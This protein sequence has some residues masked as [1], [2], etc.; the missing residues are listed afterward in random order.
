MALINRTWGNVTTWPG[1]RVRV[2][3]T[4]CIPPGTLVRTVDHPPRLTKAET[5]DWWIDTA[6]SYNRAHRIYQ[7]H[8]PYTHVVTLEEG[9]R[10]NS[11]AFFCYCTPLSGYTSAAGDGVGVGYRPTNWDMDPAPLRTLAQ[12]RALLNAGRFHSLLGSDFFQ[13]KQV[14]SMFENV[15]RRSVNAVRSLRHGKIEEALRS[16]GYH[17]PRRRLRGKD[18]ASQWL[19]IQYGWKPLWADLYDSFS[20]L[21]SM[22]NHALMKGVGRAKDLRDKVYRETVSS[23]FIDHHRKETC[24]TRCQLDFTLVDSTLLLSQ[25]LGLLNPL[26]TIWDL[27]P[28]SFVIDWFF[29]IGDYFQSLSALAGLKYLGGSV[30]SKQK[31][32]HTERGVYTPPSYCGWQSG[33][34]T[35]LWDIFMFKR[36]VLPDPPSYILKVKNPFSFMH[37]A[38][39]LALAFQRAF[40]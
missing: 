4:D 19:E 33:S 30:S 23:Y 40:R 34:S 14:F 1:E 28:W 6:F 37:G 25:Q 12:N 20:A 16:L 29:P 9:P 27:T 3:A 7:Q 31:L 21:K 24:S 36:V 39:T 2:D 35:Y 18:L 10:G 32:T 5:R 22:D 13:R 15:V 38:N 11:K 26:E 17:G 8:L